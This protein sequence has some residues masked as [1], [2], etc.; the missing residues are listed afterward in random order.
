MAYLLSKAI[1][2]FRQPLNIGIAA[3]L[4]K[5]VPML[6]QFKISPLL[7]LGLAPKTASPHLT[8]GSSKLDQ[9]NSWIE[10]PFNQYGMS[11]YIAARCTS[12]IT[13]SS[14]TI[15]LRSGMDISDFLNWVGISE[16]LQAGGSALGAAAITGIFMTPVLFL[17]LPT[18]VRIVSNIVKGSTKEK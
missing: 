16:T 14:V 15:A 18:V 3:V 13:L 4:S 6:S 2:R 7:G 5:K 12:L 8:I 9:F 10:R 1:S 17:S 11:Y